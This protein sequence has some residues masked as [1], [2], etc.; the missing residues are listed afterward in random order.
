MCCDMLKERCQLLHDRSQLSFLPDI[1]FLRLG[2]YLEGPAMDLG[3][4]IV[5]RCHP[6]ALL[7][8]A[9]DV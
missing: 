6:A 7:C 1:V 2:F 5:G 4:Y 3:H 8:I 9:A